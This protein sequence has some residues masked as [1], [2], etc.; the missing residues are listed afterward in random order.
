MKKKSDIEDNNP[1]KY[2]PQWMDIIIT[3]VCIGIIMTGMWALSASAN[4]TDVDGE[5][6]YPGEFFIGQTAAMELCFNEALKVASTI[7]FETHEDYLDAVGM[8]TGGCMYYQ[9]LD[10]A[11]CPQTPFAY[12]IEPDDRAGEFEHQF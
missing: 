6:Y 4:E 12:P 9:M 7:E 1:F 3:I 5:I 8:L 2:D 11:S 10:Q